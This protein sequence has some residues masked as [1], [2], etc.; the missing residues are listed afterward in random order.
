M[1]IKEQNITKWKEQWQELCADRFRND[2]AIA[3]LAHVIREEFP[4]GDAGDLQFRMF[5]KRHLKGCSSKTFL[6]KARA[7]LEFNERQWN[8]LGGWQGVSFLR[9]LTRKERYH[10]METLHGVG[11]FHYTTIRVRALKLGIVAKR[12]G[13]DTRSR[14]EQR[15]AVLRKF[16]ADLY[17]KHDDLPAIPNEVK[18]AM[19]PTV[20]SMISEARA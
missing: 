8:R 20:L 7:F 3:A 19:S 15:V 6:E 17:K 5:V 2:Y 13:R 9:S 1:V 11:P 10:V 12:K 16:I 18:L 4:R 14:S